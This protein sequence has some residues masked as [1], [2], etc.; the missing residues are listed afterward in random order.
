MAISNLLGN[1]PLAKAEGPVLG[2]TFRS[3]H[4]DDLRLNI[5]GN[6]PLRI[7]R[8]IRPTHVYVIV[9]SCFFLPGL[10]RKFSLSLDDFHV[11]MRRE[12]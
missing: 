12:L 8:V 11:Q 5:A 4:I 1:F 3:R 7:V 2:Q 9:P 10:R 6:G